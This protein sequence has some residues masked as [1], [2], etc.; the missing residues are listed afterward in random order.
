[1]SI[2]SNDEDSFIVPQGKNVLVAIEIGVEHK[3]LPRKL[4][5]FDVSAYC[6]LPVFHPFTALDYAV[7]GVNHT[8]NQVIAMQ[9][10][11]PVDL[12]LISF[13]EFGQLRAGGGSLQW[14]N[15]AVALEGVTLDLCDP[16]VV[17][18]L[19]QSMYQ[20][21]PIPTGSKLGWNSDLKEE[22]FLDELFR[23]ITVQLDR[24]KK[25]WSSF[26]ALYICISVVS[27]VMQTP[28]FK[29]PAKFQVLLHRCRQI[30]VDWSDSI[31]ELVERQNSSNEE[32][33]KHLFYI[34][35]LIVF[36][37]GTCHE[38]SNA[39][40]IFQSEEMIYQLVRA[41]ILMQEHNYFPT[42][43]ELKRLSIL[44]YRIIL[45]CQEKML[46]MLELQP[47]ALGMI[48]VNRLEGSK[49]ISWKP[50]NGFYQGDGTARDGLPFTVHIHIVEG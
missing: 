12:Q 23:C 1:M 4:I 20:V 14:R 24:I 16:S 7:H 35:G 44:C 9:A 42:E 28:G 39:K 49:A 8:E 33:K 17:N 50:V 3:L 18:L 41:R 22:D 31:E 21:G 38:D 48:V 26:R 10:S 30:A 34:N 5:K 6:K 37:F 27:Y 36:S 40:D 2:V 11:C 13:Q 15:I 29:F 32:L 19:L 43:L 46:P 25:S 47:E 45:R